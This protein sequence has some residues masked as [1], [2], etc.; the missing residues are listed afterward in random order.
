[1]ASKKIN[2]K[3]NNENILI[4]VPNVDNLIGWDYY[5]HEQCYLISKEV[6]SCALIEIADNIIPQIENIFLKHVK[7]N[8]L[9]FK[10]FSKNGKVII[11]IHKY[12]HQAYIFDM[13]IQPA[14][15]NDNLGFVDQYILGKLLG[16][17]EKAMHN[18]FTNNDETDNYIFKASWINSYEFVPNHTRLVLVSQNCNDYEIMTFDCEKSKFINSNY[19]L[20]PDTNLYWMALPVHPYNKYQALN[21]NDK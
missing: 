5:I 16:Y 20:D 15:E 9:K 11:F 19:E 2:A 6:R 10:I 12:N 13:L 1:M 7:S 21:D 14:I 3:N 18:Y 8:N 17:S 4:N